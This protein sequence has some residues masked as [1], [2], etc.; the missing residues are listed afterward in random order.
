MAFWRRWLSTPGATRAG[1]ERWCT[2]WRHR[3]YRLRPTG[4]IVAAPTTS[5]PEAD[6]GACNWDYRY[7]SRARLRL[8]RPP[9][10]PLHRGGRGVHE[11]A[12]P[13]LRWPADENGSLQTGCT[14]LTA[15]PSFPEEV[16]GHLEAY[17]GRDLVRVG[18]AAVDQLQLDIY[19][20]LIGFACLYNKYGMLITTDVWG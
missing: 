5:L 10:R 14:A 3:S 15:V 1:G 4:A 12:D 17:C 20:E 9:L 18:N 11:L 13:A 16:L 6:S 2:A 7:S 8:R 19:G